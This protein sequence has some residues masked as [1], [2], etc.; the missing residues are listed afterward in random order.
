MYGCPGSSFQ[1]E[2]VSLGLKTSSCSIN[3]VMDCLPPKGTNFP[4]GSEGKASVYNVEDPGSIPG[5]GRSLR[6]GKGNPLQYP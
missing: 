5:W 3:Q 1:V 6:E 4:G 2:V